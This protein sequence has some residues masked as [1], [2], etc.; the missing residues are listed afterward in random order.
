MLQSVIVSDQEY[1]WVNH[2]VDIR[3][4]LPEIM[5]LPNQNS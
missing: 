1:P 3:S 2:T 5:A 4:L